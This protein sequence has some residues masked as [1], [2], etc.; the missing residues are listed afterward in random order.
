MNSY[1]PVPV[2]EHLVPQVMKFI[3]DLE[4]ESPLT[5][6]PLPNAQRAEDP[7]TRAP[8][9]DRVDVAESESR[10]W[11]IEEL[12]LIR[13]SDKSSVRLFASVLD[14]LA[15]VSPQ[16]LTA[17]ELGALNGMPGLR[18]QNTFGAVTRWM[19]NRVGEDVRWP[20]HFREGGWYMNEHN[21]SEWMSLT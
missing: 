17:D 18:M 5:G 14:A 7:A 3:V 19:K 21:A 15:P 9:A 6:T 12:A 4:T 8:Q 20:I 16:T 11:T 10:D 13:D 1:V 2:P